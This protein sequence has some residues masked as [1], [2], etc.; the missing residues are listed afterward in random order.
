LGS[1]IEAQATKIFDMDNTTFMK[2]VFPVLEKMR[3]DNPSA[4]SDY[5]EALLGQSSHEKLLG[6]LFTVFAPIDI[7]AGAK[8]GAKVAKGMF[9][10]N[11][12]KK[13]VRDIL[14]EAK[15]PDATA[16]DITAAAG[17]LRGSAVMD[18][19]NNLQKSVSGTLDV[20]KQ[21]TVHI[22]RTSD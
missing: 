5:I 15:K 10:Y 8:L 3:K 18:V 12:G 11:A 22:P 2:T 1:N 13:A 19:A 16:A 20:E 6:N 17:D 14:A 9:T 21:L 7:Y 4:T